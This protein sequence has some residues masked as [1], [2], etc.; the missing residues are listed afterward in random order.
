MERQLFEKILEE[1]KERSKPNSNEEI[2]TSIQIISKSLSNII[3]MNNIYITLNSGNDTKTYLVTGDECKSKF[4]IDIT[5]CENRYK[6][7]WWSDEEVTEIGNIGRDFTI[8][9]M[10]RE[11]SSDTIINKALNEIIGII[12]YSD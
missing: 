7:R 10:G 8:T 11:N 12:N 4:C 5:G 3:K 6:V 9:E 2:K 1:L